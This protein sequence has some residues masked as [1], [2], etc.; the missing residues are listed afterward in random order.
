MTTVEESTT[1]EFAHAVRGYDRFQVDEYI[2]R[3]QLLVEN[4]EERVRSAEAQAG[5]A[6]VGPRVAQIFELA[7]AEANELREQ[8]ERETE[9]RAASAKQRADKVVR[10]AKQ[11]AADYEAHIRDEHAELMNALAGERDQVRAE[12]ELLERQRAELASHL[13]RLHEAIGRFAAVA[14]DA[15]QRPEDGTKTRQLKAVVAN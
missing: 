5:H 8:A 11:V 9:Q 4:A 6:A 12:V 14:D 15:E 7:M 3:L 2:A 13:R 1:P 10:T